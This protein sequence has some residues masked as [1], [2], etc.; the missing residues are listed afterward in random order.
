VGLVGE[1]GGGGGGGISRWGC[2]RPSGW[3][4]AIRH[5]GSACT[6]ASTCIGVPLCSHLC[7]M[8][9]CMAG[10]I[11]SCTRRVLR[12]QG[13]YCC[14]VAAVLV[15]SSRCETMTLMRIITARTAR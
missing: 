4:F 13:Y 10:L 2:G 14:A 12:V 15:L 6:L 3:W 1:Y 9:P 8:L 5:V 11:V 7:H